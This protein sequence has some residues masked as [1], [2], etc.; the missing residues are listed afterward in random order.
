MQENV[1]FLCEHGENRQPLELPN[2][3][4]ADFY[5][6]ADA[7]LFPSTKEGFGIPILEAG[8]ARLPIFAA[9]IPPVRESTAGLAHLFDPHG[10]P[11]TVAR[12]I[13]AYLEKDALFQM[14]RRVI[15]QYTW[16]SVVFR[17]VLPLIEKAIQ[18]GK[19]H[20][21]ENAQNE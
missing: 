19:K 2:E 1:Y 9:D 5:H 14:R 6:L 11:Q 20:E 10:E 7:L 21:C 8:L 18:E 17:Q 16:E 3:V 4:L 15:H 13:V 12:E